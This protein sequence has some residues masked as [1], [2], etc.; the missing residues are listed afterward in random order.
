MAPFAAAVTALAHMH[1]QWD[2]VA[3]VLG[4]GGC[5]EV[6]ADHLFFLSSLVVC[7]ML[8][9][10]ISPQGVAWHVGDLGMAQ[11]ARP[12]ADISSRVY[13]IA[14]ERFAY[15]AIYNVGRRWV[16][17]SRAYWVMSCS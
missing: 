16:R 6:I 14:S 7:S 12:D 2:V 3:A 10:F 17:C 8:I 15:L 11:L 9:F 1:M 4:R 13:D 5:M